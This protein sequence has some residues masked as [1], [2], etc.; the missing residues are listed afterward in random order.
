MALKMF[1]CLALLFIFLSSQ[2]LQ[3]PGIAVARDFEAIIASGKIR[4]AI[5]EED[6]I[7]WL[8][9]DEQGD[10]I[11][12]EVD[13][14]REMIEG[15]GVE[16]EFVQTPFA[17]LITTLIAGE[18]DM[19]VSGLSVTPERA[20]RVLY[21]VPYGQ[22]DLELVVDISQLPEGAA[23]ESFDMEGMRI[24]VVAATTLEIEGRTH[25]PNSEIVVFRNEEEARDAFL[26]GKVNAIIASKPYPDF[27]E[28]R[29]PERFVSA[30]DPLTST[31]EAV[32]VAPDNF[33]LLNYANA[34]IA[35]AMASGFLEEA[36]HYW[37]ETLDWADQVP[38]LREQIDR[39]P[40]PSGSN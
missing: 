25:F 30:G 6:F 5:A 26:D 20:R 1:R 13:I 2:M 28:S 23:E 32:A 22:S 16:P 21:S 35:Q 33:R 19:I 11:G 12:F 40:S 38:G 24:A 4:I 15:L 36:T 8:M 17:D 18:V 34:W 9:R 39:Y 37:F 3:V 10:P 7:P 27:I 29:D 31:V 14:G